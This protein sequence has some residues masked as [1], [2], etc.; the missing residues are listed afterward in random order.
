MH[1]KWRGILTRRQRLQCLAQEAA[2]QLRTAQ[3][4]ATEGACLAAEAAVVREMV[5]EEETT[6]MKEDGK[7]RWTP[8]STQRM[9]PMKI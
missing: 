8:G 2:L 6:L 9:T 5:T 3:M 1:F 7:A 4:A